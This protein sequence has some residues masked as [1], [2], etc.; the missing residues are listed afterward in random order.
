MGDY[1]GSASSIGAH[2]EK[3]DWKRIRDRSDEWLNCRPDHTWYS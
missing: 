2:H 3:G 1:T